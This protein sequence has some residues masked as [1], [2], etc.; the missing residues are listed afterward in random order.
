MAEVPFDPP[1]TAQEP[2]PNVEQ[3]KESSVKDELVDLYSVHPWLRIHHKLEEYV[4]PE[5]YDRLLKP[6]VFEGLLDLEHLRRFV[7]NDLRSGARVLELGCGTGRATK[8]VLDSL[9]GISQLDLVDLSNRMLDKV[10]RRFSSYNCINYINS[11]AILHLERTQSTYDLIF[12]LW[13]FSHSVHQNLLSSSGEARV[14]EAIKKMA[15]HN[16]ASGSRFFLIHFDS[17]SDEQKILMRQWKKLYPSLFGDIEKQSPSKRLIDEVLKELEDEGTLRFAVKHYTGAPIEYR[18]VE[19]ALE[20]FVNFH[21]ESAFN[22]TGL[23]MDVVAEVENYIRGFAD[24]TGVVR[25][26]PGCFIYTVSRQ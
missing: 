21:L 24:E 1:S 2:N 6:Y 5:Y 23:M 11:D 10:M 15:R 12:S 8:V 14:R 20:T 26:A 25:I 3:D 22:T 13:S 7:E 19:E 4:A 18:S 9:E 17:L 16:M